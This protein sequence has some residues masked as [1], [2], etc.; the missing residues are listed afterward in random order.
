MNKES[1]EITDL[2]NENIN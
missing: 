2:T 1:L